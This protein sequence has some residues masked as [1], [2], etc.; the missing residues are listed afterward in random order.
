MIDELKDKLDELIAAQERQAAACER[1]ADLLDSIIATV[2]Y[3]GRQQHEL[4]VST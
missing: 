1:I 2:S 3:G 4:Q